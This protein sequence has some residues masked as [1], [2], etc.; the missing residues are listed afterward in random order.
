MASVD[1]EGVAFTAGVVGIAV[2]FLYFARKYGQ[3]EQKVESLERGMQDVNK[4]EGIFGLKIDA[5]N[6]RVQGMETK[7]AGLDVKVDNMKESVDDVKELM[8]EHLK[9]VKRA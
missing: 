3:L 4:S 2:N 9:D 1:V 7:I 5:I 8:I 6:S